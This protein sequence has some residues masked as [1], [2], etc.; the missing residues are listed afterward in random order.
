MGIIWSLSGIAKLVLFWLFVGVVIG[1][2]LDSRAAAGPVNS[3]PC[4]VAAVGLHPTHGGPGYREE[5]SGWK[6]TTM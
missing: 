1:L 3:D 2:A 4:S 5:V 6:L